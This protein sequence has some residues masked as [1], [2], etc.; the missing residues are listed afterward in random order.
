MKLKRRAE[1]TLEELAPTELTDRLTRLY[2]E[3]WDVDD[4]GLVV[5]IN[6]YW[7]AGLIHSESFLIHDPEEERFFQWDEIDGIYLPESRFRVALTVASRLLR[8]S[9]DIRRPELTDFRSLKTCETI[10]TILRSVSEV[11]DP[12][13][14][15]KPI[16]ALNDGVVEL[17]GGKVE[18]RRF[19]PKFLLC[20]KANVS[21]NRKA[22]CPRFLAEFLKPMLPDEDVDLAQRYLGLVF[23]GINPMNRMGVFEGESAAG[24][25]TL[26]NIMVA[27]RG[28]G[29]CC[30]LRTE[31]LDKQFELEAFRGRDLLLGV[32]VGA[33][34]LNSIGAQTLKGL[35]S[36]DLYHPE[37]KGRSDRRPLRGPFNVLIATN[38]KLTYR[39]QGDGAAWARRL[40]IFDCRTPERRK[41]IPGFDVV[42]LKAEGSGIV[43]WLL[44]GLK[45]AMREI[46]NHG[47]LVLS[48]TQLDRVNQL[49]MRSEAA[50]A[51]VQR[52]LVADREED[53]T[54]EELIEAFYS[55]CA[56]RGWQPGSD[57]DFMVKL[58]SIIGDRFGR[59]K[60]GD[61]ERNGKKTRKGWRGLKLVDEGWR[62]SG[63][64]F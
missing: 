11:R 9:R 12:F 25:T 8:A 21:Y 4:K 33:T 58:S 17:V 37:A 19:D 13:H 5:R 45:K 51:F 2:G 31:H 34:F 57:R 7:W 52:C 53:V 48:D 54:S 40:L 10:R 62:S 27:L 41:K 60:A 32:D 24:K 28:E 1:E 43:N 18:F 15:K 38:C 22:T 47:D 64:P 59:P 3:P 63:D 61:L 29:R 44:E 36:T 20:H 35:C 30:Q 39:S 26:V 56:A 6:P 14:H 49:V 42:L 50:E 55:F 23:V 46:E 16:L